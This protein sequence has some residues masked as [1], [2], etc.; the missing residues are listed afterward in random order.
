MTIRILCLPG[1]IGLLGLLMFAAHARAESPDI[2]AVNNRVL[3]QVMST[4]V[5]YTE[6]GTDT[7]GPPPACWI[8]KRV[9]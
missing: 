2:G 9:P 1:L 6:M 8:P 5:D 7:L 3:L 4:R